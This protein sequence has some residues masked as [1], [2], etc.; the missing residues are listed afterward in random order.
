MAWNIDATMIELC[1]CKA[2]CPCWLGPDTEPDHGWCGGALLFEIDKGAVDGVDV[3][4]CRA[5]LAADWPG[6]FFG[7]NG[8]ARLYLD[9]AASQAQRTALE[10]V[11]SGKKGGMFGNVLGHV[12]T[13][14]LPS[15]TAA[16]TIDRNGA[17]SARVEGVSETKV[18]PYQDQTGRTVMVEGTAAQCAFQSPS[19]ELASSKGSRWTDDGLPHAWEGD[20]GTIHRRMSWSG[21]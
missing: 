7:G 8:T 15:K 10:A 12:V 16:I 20:S 3:S 6:N 13:H 18:T 9:S 21:E 14:W 1:S 19:M 11:L 2:M 4:G 5:A 17:I